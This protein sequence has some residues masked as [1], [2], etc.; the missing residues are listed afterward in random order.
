[1]R[2]RWWIWMLAAGCGPGADEGPEAVPDGEEPAVVDDG[3]PTVD[4]LEA[5]LQ[6]AVARSMTIDGSVLQGAYDDAMS[7]GGAA[8]PA[9]SDD[10]GDYWYDSCKT[11]DGAEFNGYAY[12]FGGDAP[13]GSYESYWYVYGEA[14]IERPDGTELDLGGYAGWGN[15]G[16]GDM[17]WT[18]HYAYGTFGSQSPD[19][20]DTWLAMSDS[21]DFYAIAGRQDLTGAKYVYLDGALGTLQGNRAQAADFVAVEL[22]AMV[23]PAC[24]GAPRG[25]VWLR[26]ADAQWVEVRFDC[27]ACGVALLGSDDLGEVCADFSAWT[28][29]EDAP[30]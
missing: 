27:D 30:W 24:A 22:G 21:V 13:P 1:M 5:L 2:A 25:S 10:F 16:E 19:H 17:S 8:C 7:M 14:T 18:Y 26:T 12:A 28:Q 3:V 9:S 4:A 29:W 11:S 20:D 15:Y 23:D 6:E